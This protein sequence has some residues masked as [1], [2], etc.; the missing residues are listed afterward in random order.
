[1]K[2][3]IIIIT[4]A[5]QVITMHA[6][7]WPD[8]SDYRRKF[9]DYASWGWQALKDWDQK[10]TEDL[11][12]KKMAPEVEAGL[13]RLAEVSKRGAELAYE[14]G[15]K[16]AAQGRKLYEKIANP[17]AEAAKTAFLRLPRGSRNPE[18][19]PHF[20][21]PHF[22]GVSVQDLI[23][24]RNLPA[25]GFSQENS[26]DRGSFVLDLSNKYIND[27]S[28]L[29]NLPNKE[30]IHGLRLNGNRLTSFDFGLLDGFTNIRL[31]NL[32][33]NPLS[34]ETLAELETT[35]PE[36]LTIESI[37]RNA[38]PPRPEEE[39]SSS[40]FG[41]AAQIF[42]S[43]APRAQAPTP[44]LAEQ[45]K[46]RFLTLPTLDA[47]LLPERLYHHFTGVSI[48]DL[49]NARKLPAIAGGVLDLSNKSINSL[50][51]IDRIPNKATVTQLLLNRNRLTSVP[52]SAFNGFTDLRELDLKDN[53]I[54]TLPS[55]SF[56][57]LTNLQRL[58]LSVNELESLP[59]QIF[60]PLTQ[61]QNINLSHN[62]LRTIDSSI[63]N[64]L[65]RLETIQLNANRL[66]ELPL[67][68]INGHDALRL[69]TLTNNQFAPEEI[70]A[71][72]RTITEAK[73]ARTLNPNLETIIDSLMNTSSYLPTFF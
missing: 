32:T 56:T 47:N 45:A 15:K 50:D 19:L 23:N 72:T 24:T 39:Q 21:F 43:P 71:I 53:L 6:A 17:Q 64:G 10:L 5:A 60:T 9:A 44:D 51:G 35:K 70:E 27:A 22:T 63:F 68:V 62:Q 18:N 31:L 38:A 49:I 66:Q 55:Q 26:T 2:K 30:G 14:T 40:W 48:D 42:R 61:L 46:N 41:Q 69:L 8:T 34:T 52:S 1:M 67:A 12:T 36:G 33:G 28:G 11:T 25:L 58:D 59:A 57:A 29:E 37:A 7:A 4:L 73:T 16:A 20:L 54:V 3:A 13:S 65:N